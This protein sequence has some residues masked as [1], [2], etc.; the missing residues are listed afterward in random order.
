MRQGTG[1]TGPACQNAHSEAANRSRIRRPR[2][3]VHASR[4]QGQNVD[5]DLVAPLANTSGPSWRA[6]VRWAKSRSHG[7]TRGHRVRSSNPGQPVLGSNARPGLSF[8]RALPK[9]PPRGL[10]QHAECHAT[11]RPFESPK[12][13]LES[14]GG[15]RRALGWIPLATFGGIVGLEQP[16][17]SWLGPEGSR[18][19]V[20]STRNGG[21][22]SGEGLECRLGS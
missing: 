15:G 20:D 6:P 4:C 10:T 1:K 13:L 22:G 21:D 2:R 7:T 17:R 16:T 11:A 12:S 19:T 5:G 8:G 14:S 9:G 3:A 18:E